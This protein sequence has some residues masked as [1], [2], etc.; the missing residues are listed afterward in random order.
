MTKGFN[1]EI[2]RQQPNKMGI[3]KLFEGMRETLS[4]PYGKG[5]RNVT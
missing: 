3:E 4:A 2:R 5:K 1:K